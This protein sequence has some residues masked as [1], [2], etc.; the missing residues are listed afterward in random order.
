MKLTAQM[1]RDEALMRF[2]RKYFQSRQP[3]IAYD[4]TICGNW[5]PF[6]DDCQVTFFE[7]DLETDGVKVSWQVY[8]A[9]SKV[10]R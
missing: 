6:K 8:N 2:T 9:F 10:N 5:S 4:G 7:N 1:D 3:V